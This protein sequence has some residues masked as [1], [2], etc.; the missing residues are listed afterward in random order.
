M[1]RQNSSRHVNRQQGRSRRQFLGDALTA[2]AAAPLLAGFAAEGLAQESKP[3][4][5]P[6]KIKLGLVGCGGRG[7]WIAGLFVSVPPNTSC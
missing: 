1:N 3:A 5:L 7:S 6:R 4:T 2:A